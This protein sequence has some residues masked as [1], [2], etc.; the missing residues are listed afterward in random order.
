[1][2]TAAVTTLAAPRKKK[3]GGLAEVL[4]RLRKSPLAMFGL[5]FIIFLAFVAIFANFLAPY[6]YQKQ[7]L[8]HSY[9][10][11]SKQYWLG[12]DEF[13]RDILSRLIYGARISLQV[14]FI[15]VGI[16]LVIGGMLGPRR[17]ITGGGST[18]AS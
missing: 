16:A 8:M 6:P 9:E 3:R 14:G 10:T 4:F 2:N 13:G 11:P 5:V 1:M 15:A 7:N 17:D 18:T 12:T